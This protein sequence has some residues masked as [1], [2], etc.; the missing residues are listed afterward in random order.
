LV[1]VVAGT[2]AALERVGNLIARV[3][4]ALER[5]SDVGVERDGPELVALAVDSEVD[6][7]ALVLR[8]A[9]VERVERQ[10]PRL[11]RAKARIAEDWISATSRIAAGCEPRVLAEPA[12]RARATVRTRS[13]VRD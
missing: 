3:A 7:A 12:S 11:A 8:A 9:L 6:T 13:H 2:A 1:G 5:D 10:R 4:P